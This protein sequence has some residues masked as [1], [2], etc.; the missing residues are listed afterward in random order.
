L[1]TIIFGAV[2]P[3]LTLSWHN[4]NNTN[5]GT[6]VPNPA[7]VSSGTYFAFYTDVN[8]CNSPSSQVQ[9]T[10]AMIG[11]CTEPL[12][13]EVSA[14]AGSSNVIMFSSALTPPPSYLVKRR[15]ATDPDVSGSYTTIGVPVFNAGI[16]KWQIT[17]NTSVSNTLYVY[18]AESQCSDGGR[19]YALYTFANFTCP[20]VV[21][22]PSS[23]GIGY[24]FVPQGG[25]ISKYDVQL[26]D[27]TETTLID[28]D[29]YNPAFSNPTT[30]AFTG[31]T[32]ST[33]YK[34][35]VL[36]Y[37]GTSITQYCAFITTG[38]TAPNGTINVLVN[39]LGLTIG[40]DNASGTITG[41]P[42]STVNV[43]INMS[44][45]DAAAV[46]NYNINGT[47]GSITNAGTGLTIP[48]VLPGGG[49]I[50]WTLDLV[51]TVSSE[52]STIILV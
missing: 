50:A 26:Y 9:I 6:L 45:T 30:G 7:S 37:I 11:N 2:P 27:S 24:S 31:L 3:G 16:S 41:A 18:K 22:T 5:A 14:G 21:L 51:T 20:S 15:L 29:T 33:A 52:G 39:F 19:P 8:G 36:E 32:A 13:L 12:S 1:G 47:V 34:I 46:T 38:T 4:A 49:S 35:R 17:D 48:F 43:R 40:N 28:T 42:S 10:C 44:G 23:N 25:Q